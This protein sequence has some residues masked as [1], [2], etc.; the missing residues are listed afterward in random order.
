M[1]ICLNVHTL[2]KT[3]PLNT[4]M[5]TTIKQ[6]MVEINAV[7]PCT[8]RQLYRYF[9]ALKIAPAGSIRQRPQRYPA[10]TAR[11]VL[12]KLGFDDPTEA[13]RSMA[14]TVRP[15]PAILSMNQIKR[16]KKGGSK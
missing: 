8:Q 2:N 5:N 3:G 16:A 11:R 9:K 12:D 14:E 15:R 4:Y 13:T 1:Q 10:D 7:R 6:I